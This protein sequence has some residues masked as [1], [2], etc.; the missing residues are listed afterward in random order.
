MKAEGS[1]YYEYIFLY[2]DEAISI[3]ENGKYVLWEYIENY[4]EMK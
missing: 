1:E 3:S 4:F 2:T